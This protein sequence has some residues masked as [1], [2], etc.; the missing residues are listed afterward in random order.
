MA[1]VIIRCPRCDAKTRLSLI[2][3]VYEGPYRCWKCQGLFTIR[4]DDNEV[5]SC[6]PLTETEFEKG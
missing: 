5:R 3:P 6:E 4:I 2:D 1:K